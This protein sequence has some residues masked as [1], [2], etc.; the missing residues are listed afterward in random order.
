M[1]LGSPEYNG[2]RYKPHADTAFLRVGADI[3]NWSDEEND[4]KGKER[5]IAMFESFGLLVPR[6]KN[7]DLGWDWRAY[8]DVG[9]PGNILIGG[10]AT[11]SVGVPTSMVMVA[12]DGQIITVERQ[13][14]PKS[15]TPPLTT[16][17]TSPADSVWRTLVVRVAQTRY[18]PGVILLTNGV[19]AFLGTGTDFTR[20]SAVTTNGV[21]IGTRIQV[22]AADSVPLAGEYEFD[23]IATGTTG[24]LT[25]ATTPTATGTVPFSVV[26][27]Y[28]LAS[29][30]AVA[31]RDIYQRVVP[32][33]QLVARTMTPAAGDYVIADVWYDGVTVRLIDR[34]KKNLLRF[35]DPLSQ[36]YPPAL[37]PMLD[38]DVTSPFTG[39][40][41]QEW[42]FLASGNQNGDV[43][44]T[45]SNALLGHDLFVFAIDAAANARLYRYEHI[46]GVGGP[47][48]GFG[49]QTLLSTAYTGANG[50]HP[51]M[52][53]VATQ[54]GTELFIVVYENGAGDLLMR[55]ST[56]KVA[57]SGA[58]V[59][60][61]P[62][63]IDA[64]DT[65]TEPYLIELK[66]GRIACY[67]IYF[68]NSAGNRNVRVI[69][70]DDKTTTWNTT[71]NAG[72]AVT[73]VTVNPITCVSAAQDLT[74]GTVYV[75]RCQNSLIR[76][77]L[78][79]D[80]GGITAE[81]TGSLDLGR[82]VD[83]ASVMA[84][85]DCWVSPSGYLV[86]VYTERVDGAAG[87]LDLRY[88]VYSF[89]TGIPTVFQ[90]FSEHI[91]RITDQA[92]HGINIDA[93]D[94]GRPAI[95]QAPWGLIYCFYVVPG[96][97]IVLKTLK[98]IAMPLAAPID[99]T[100]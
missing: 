89:Q 13:H 42:Q 55:T 25:T 72:I 100:Y 38:V 34:R 36:M 63:A 96:D 45:V 53:R 11:G 75:V 80:E 41:Q 82:I 35:R 97:N 16:G 54:I 47:P 3:L 68:D 61:Q 57:W 44:V 2:V 77:S 66:N 31:D 18:A 52:I 15:T 92:T 24:N 48:M 14:E 64:L 9:N 86:V 83:A 74:R 60:W 32:E 22:N 8:E 40:T 62:T 50:T 87:F 71:G 73:T 19:V 17:L 28:Q 33:F 37:V 99:T 6:N 70:T 58:S 79:I 27:T 21:P 23:T 98:P 94:R 95:W 76:V 10:E 69:Y 81:D 1:S 5:R 90:A 65:V 39:M 20:F 4:E 7:G 29:P 78:I 49:T 84:D 26:G 59:I 12:D 93:N 91:Q 30:A 46:T 43:S 51:H 67:A 85:C 56:N 88:A